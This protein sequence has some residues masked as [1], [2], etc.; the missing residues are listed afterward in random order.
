[1]CK[2]KILYIVSHPIQ[3]QAPLLRLIAESNNIDITVAFYWNKK[4]DAHFDAGFGKKIIWDIPLL[5]GYQYIYLSDSK[6]KLKKLWELISSKK[7]NI[8]WTH[9]YADLY[10]FSA[11]AFAKINR[12]KI[13]VRGE[14]LYFLNEKPNLKKILFFKMLNKLVDRFL[15]IGENNKNFYIQNGIASHKIF[16][17]NYAV[18]N[19]FFKKKYFEIKNKLA[20]YRNQ[21][22]LDVTR[23]IILYASKFLNRKHAMDLL[24]AYILLSEHNTEPKPYLLLIGTG[25]AYDDVAKKA[26]NTKWDSIRFLGFKNQSELPVYFAL[27]D[28]FVLPSTRENWGLVVNEAMNAECAVIVSDQVGC[29]VDLIQN[30]ENG[31]IYPARD[32]HMLATHLKYLIFHSEKCEKMKIKSAAIISHWGL[33]ESILGLHAACRSLTCDENNESF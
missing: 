23:P 14:S 20:E 11:I 29:A 5:S 17:C 6:Y 19:D 26:K 9:G 32:I 28:I 8:I 16:L 1:M 10:T 13:F 21:L 3:Y 27:A 24:D 18:D 2:Y 15:A 4:S 25:E 31:Y 22:N 12:L 30:G 7:Y 33:K